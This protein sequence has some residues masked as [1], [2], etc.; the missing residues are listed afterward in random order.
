[1]YSPDAVLFARRAVSCALG[2]FLNEVTHNT[3]SAMSVTRSKTFIDPLRRTA[4][5]GMYQIL[6]IYTRALAHTAQGHCR[7]N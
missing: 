1:M 2:R 7:A 6:I 3:N 5:G 4:Q